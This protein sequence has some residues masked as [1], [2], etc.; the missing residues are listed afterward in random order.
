VLFQDCSSYMMELKSAL[1]DHSIQLVLFMCVYVA[2][3]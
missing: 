3:Y 1:L 2:Y